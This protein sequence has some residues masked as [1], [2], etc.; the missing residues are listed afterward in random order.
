MFIKTLIND[1]ISVFKPEIYHG[2]AKKKSFFEGWYFKITDKTKSKTFVFI[3]GISKYTNDRHSFIQFFH[4]GQLKR[5]YFRFPIESFKSEFNTFEINIENNI[6]ST[7]HLEFNLLSDN[8]TING[9]LR[10]S[11]LNRWKVTPLNPG[12]M[13]F[14]G[15]IPFMECYYD[16]IAAKGTVNGSLSIDGESTDFNGGS[17]YIE[18]NWGKSFP[19]EW[20][21]IQG[22]NFD[23][24]NTGFTFS[25]ATIP[26]GLLHFNGLTAG[27][28][29]KNK[30]IKFATYN[31]TR[32]IKLNVYDNKI[33]IV[34]KKGKLYLEL[35]A[36]SNDTA[37]LPYP[38]PNGMNG[39][40]NESV[41]GTINLKI[42]KKNGKSFRTIFQGQ[43]SNCGIEIGGFRNINKE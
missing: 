43:S 35:N 22:N 38:T 28:F 19:T 1:L 13:G 40:I 11:N 16:L 29:Y 2:F 15:I 24:D 34:L 30:I 25:Y 18:K 12:I 39:T 31:L 41:T 9:S 5:E 17:V 14:F 23:N 26:F 3:P 32:V 8:K 33:E 4:N 36:V 20:I 21:W 27:L 7:D 10:L 42:S 37:S 6:F